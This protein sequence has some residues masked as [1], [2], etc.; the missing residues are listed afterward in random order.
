MDSTRSSARPLF[1]GSLLAVCSGPLIF[2]ISVIAASRLAFSATMQ[3]ASHAEALTRV[4]VFAASTGFLSVL[5]LIDLLLVSTATIT[6]TRFG[7][8]RNNSFLVGLVA[9]GSLSATAPIIPL[10][11]PFWAWALLFVVPPP[12]GIA[13]AFLSKLGS[14]RFKEI[15]TA[16]IKEAA[17]LRTLEQIES[18]RHYTENYAQ[19]AAQ[20]RVE[21]DTDRKSL[22]D[23]KRK[24]DRERA[25][26]TARMRA[27]ARAAFISHP[28]AA[29]ADFDRCWPE[30]RDDLLK[31]HTLQLLTDSAARLDE[32][33]PDIQ[34]ASA[35][36]M[37]RLASVESNSKSHGLGGEHVAGG[38]RN[39]QGTYQTA[40]LVIAAA[41]D[42]SLERLRA[43]ISAGA[44]MN[45]RD[46]EGWTPLMV[47]ALKGH[48][49]TVVL[50]LSHGA[51][52]ETR[53]NSG[54][55]ALRFAS[56]VGD[57]E[58]MSL[59]IGYG[60]D[61]NSRDDNRQ[62]ILM[63]AA[64]EGNISSVR[65]LLEAGA[66]K[67][68]RNLAHESAVSIALRKGHAEIVQLLRKSSLSPIKKTMS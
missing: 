15:K 56:S 40:L 41:R 27:I 30:I 37:L 9:A 1:L 46:S 25:N 39:L 61:V 58:M 2:V 21:V 64:E 60:A 33:T 7:K 44:D 19:L 31:L 28:A 59:L 54:W 29:A 45:V 66:D 11:L 23:E 34:R 14:R 12:V 5:L 67:E 47:A 13:V 52:I 51:H 49:K 48:A 24:L 17:R 6:A 43:L 50:L 18:D 22:L 16:E 20:R 65:E 8:D 10:H 38:D 32:L 4:S 55:T 3:G 62:T 35:Q 57:T 26:A 53:N 36:S 68:A 63:Q 42:G